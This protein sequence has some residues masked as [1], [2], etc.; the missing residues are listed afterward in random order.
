MSQTPRRHG[1]FEREV[2]QRFTRAIT[3]HNQALFPNSRGP[4]I[5][6]RPSW[7]T[8]DSGYGMY[9][10]P[11]FY[12]DEELAAIARQRPYWP[13]EPAATAWSR[14]KQDLAFFFTRKLGLGTTV[15]FAGT[16][17]EMPATGGPRDIKVGGLKAGGGLRLRF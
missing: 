11:E 8:K 2:D 15:E 7:D 5:L 10:E 4:R 13:N 14:Y 3:A 1:R 6:P 12:T 17:V 16:T 9:H